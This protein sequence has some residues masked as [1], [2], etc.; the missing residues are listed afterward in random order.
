VL[1]LSQ[2]VP[3]LVAGDELGRTQGGN[4]NGYC[5][6]NEISWIDWQSMDHALLQFTAGLIALRREHPV[7]RR[8]RWFQGLSI[9]GA[10]LADIGWFKPDGVQMTEGDWGSLFAKSIAVFLNGEGIAT[11]DRWGRT[12]VDDDFYLV[13]NQH[14]DTLEFSLPGELRERG[15]WRFVLDT[16]GG[17][18]GPEGE[19]GALVSAGFA[20]PGYS[21]CMLQRPRNGT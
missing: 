17:Q 8:R 10:D 2:G 7:F 15:A 12:V 9:R 11:P 4:N 18:V 16:A 1:F 19:R 6:D 13:F 3:M 5:Q 14:H 21:I 20:L